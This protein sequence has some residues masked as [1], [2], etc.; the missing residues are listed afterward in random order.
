ME[1]G[2]FGGY[3]LEVWA[4]GLYNTHPANPPHITKRGATMRHFCRLLVLTRT[5]G[6]ADELQ[7]LAPHLQVNACHC[8]HLSVASSGH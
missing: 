4:G 6:T 7:H 2:V 5:T 3:A 8:L 1:D